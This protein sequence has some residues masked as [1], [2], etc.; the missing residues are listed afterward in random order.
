MALAAKNELIRITSGK[1]FWQ[2]TQAKLISRLAYCASGGNEVAWLLSQLC[3]KPEE[4]EATVQP[5]ELTGLS[6]RWMPLLGQQHCYYPPCDRVFLAKPTIDS[7][8][9]INSHGSHKAEDD[10]GTDHSGIFPSACLFN[11]SSDANCAF[12]SVKLR[13]G[14]KVSEILAVMTIRAVK[15]GEELNVCY[16]QEKHAE[17]QWCIRER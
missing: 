6:P 13:D 17:N 2:A 12:A 8:V 14:S 15:E 7:I 10:Q 3:E 11:H 1:T 5:H 9:L 16:S 4:T